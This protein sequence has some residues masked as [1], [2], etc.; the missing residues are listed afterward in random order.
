MEMEMERGG[1]GASRLPPSKYLSR[2]FEFEPSHALMEH[3]RREMGGGMSGQM[4]TFVVPFLT[5]AI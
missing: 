1:G 3:H 2:V 5:I 4:K